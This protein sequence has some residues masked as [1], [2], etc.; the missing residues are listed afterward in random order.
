M[1]WIQTLISA[2]DLGKKRKNLLITK[3]LELN[4]PNL[5]YWRIK[6]KSVPKENTLNLTKQKMAKGKKKLDF[7]LKKEKKNPLNPRNFDRLKL[8]RDC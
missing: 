7:K 5:S 4:L 2:T 8:L 6:I 1:P 3:D